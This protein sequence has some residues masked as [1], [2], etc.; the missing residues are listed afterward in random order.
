[1]RVAVVGEHNQETYGMIKEIKNTVS[2][3]VMAKCHILF[4]C[5]YSA[6]VR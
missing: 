2:I 4:G 1:M 5:Q 6:G 3:P